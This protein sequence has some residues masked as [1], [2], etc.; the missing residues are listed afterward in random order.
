MFILIVCEQDQQN[1]HFSNSSK[2]EPFSVFVSEN[3]DQEST[4]GKLEQ[5]FS[6]EK[7]RPTASLKYVLELKEVTRSPEGVL[8]V[9]LGNLCWDCALEI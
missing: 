6:F 8:K 3:G 2:N 7:S 9:G 1:L 5:L 4:A